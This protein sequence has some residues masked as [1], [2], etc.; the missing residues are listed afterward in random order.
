MKIKV[1][2]TTEIADHD[3]VLAK[4]HFKWVMNTRYTSPENYLMLSRKN[5][6]RNF[7]KEQFQERG[8]SDYFIHLWDLFQH[9]QLNSFLADKDKYIED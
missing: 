2:Y 4:A 3:L 9:G 6:F 5:G 7:L 8:A 1:S